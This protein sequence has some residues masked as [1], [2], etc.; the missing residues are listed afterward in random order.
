MITSHKAPD[1]DSIGSSLGLYHF[2]R[3]KGFNVHVCHP[4]PA[5]GFLTWIPGYESISNLENHPEKTIQYLH[6][7]D[8]IF[9][10]DYNNS[11]RIGKMEEYLVNSKAQ[12][13]MI[14]HH[15]DPQEDLCELVFSD[16]N[17]SSTSEM[18]CMLIEAMG[19]LDMLN[20]TIGTPLYCGIM[21]D[22]GSFR[23]ASTTSKT[24]YFIGRLMEAGVRHW[25]IH[26]NVYDTGSLGKIR[27]WSYAALEKLVLLPDYHMAYIWLTQEE[28]LKFG[29]VKG[30]TEGLVNYV[31]G[32][33]GVKMSVF[34][35]ESEGMIKMSFRSQDQ[36]PVNE[37]AKSQFDG[38]GHLNAS[39]GRYIG[40][41]EDAIQKL[42]E[43]LPDFY[44]ENRAA[45][46]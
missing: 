16:F 42:N 44:A 40:K 11:G 5:P 28:E 19:D 10:L 21:T 24:H 23:F 17:L 43:V 34:L 8:I 18:I 41:M 7:A 29:V 36:I 3:L 2:L 32:I 25:E 4:D 13:V 22:T 46:P 30:D 31:L 14:D 6:E 15:R 35:K 45:F 1:G 9:C 27:L 26:E 38:G 39:G 33:E 20:Q 12:K 37:L